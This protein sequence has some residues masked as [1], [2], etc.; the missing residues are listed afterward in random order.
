MLSEGPEPGQ[1]VTFPSLGFPICKM[2]IV[3]L[4]SWAQWDHG[5]KLCLESTEPSAWLSVGPQWRLLP[6]ST[7]D[8]CSRPPQAHGLPRGHLVQWFSAGVV[9]L[10]GDIWPC[11]VTLLVV[12][13]WG[14]VL[15]TSSSWSP[16][17][18][19][20]PSTTLALMLASESIK[21]AGEEW[22]LILLPQ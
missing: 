10:P 6:G 1:D 13:T 7:E 4:V 14:Q 21:Q 19:D 15:R 22:S 3:V 16:R 18:W 8:P 5:V 11:P 2:G 12:L 9:P 20:R 17:T